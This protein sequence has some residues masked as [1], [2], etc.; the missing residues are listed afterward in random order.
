MSEK[1]RDSFRKKVYIRKNFI[2]KDYFYE[3]VKNLKKKKKAQ[4]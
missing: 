1:L 3:I 4:Y 2:K